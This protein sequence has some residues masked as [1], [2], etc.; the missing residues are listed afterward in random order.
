MRT[1]IEIIRTDE[2]NHKAEIIGLSNDQIIINN[3]TNK[4]IEFWDLE[5]LKQCLKFV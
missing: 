5:D 3:L 2:V 4:T 1:E